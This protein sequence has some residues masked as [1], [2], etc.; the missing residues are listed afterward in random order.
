MSVGAA[1]GAD[2]VEGG[3]GGVVG[4]IE[5]VQVALGGGDR[6]MPE[7]FLDDLEVGAAGQ[8]PGCVGVAE[9]VDADL[10]VQVGLLEG[11][12]PDPV[13]EPVGGDVA[14][15][16]AAAG[17]ARV[18]LAVGAAAGPVFGEGSSAVVA[19]TFGG[20]V[21][22]Q[23]AV[24][25]S[26]SLGVLLGPAEC[27]GVKRGGLLLGCG[28]RL[29]DEQ[30][31]VGTE[32]L[33]DD[34]VFEFGDDLVAE[35]E[36]TPLFIF[37]VVLDQEAF[38][39]GMEL[40]VE[41]HYDAADRQ[42]AGSGFEVAAA[43]FGEF[44]PAQAG[45]DGGLDEEFGVG[46]R[47]GVVEVVE[48]L[49]TDDFQRFLGDGGGADS[50]AG[51]DVGHLVVQRGGEDGAEDDLVVTDGGGGDAVLL[52]APDPGADVLG[53]DVHHPH[54]AE[55]GHDVLVD[56]VVVALHGGR[57]DLVVGQPGLLDVLLEGLPSPLEVEVPPLAYLGL[58]ALPGPVGLLLGGERPR[59][60]DL[61]FEVFV[62]GRVARLAV[63]VQP[64][65]R[66]PQR[67]SPE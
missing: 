5:G 34:V 64:L 57:L 59:R 4:V 12:L 18:V 24:P 52:H 23:R 21:G 54:R 61:A 43:E 1:A 51:V 2:L 42:E 39:L 26:A 55:L 33:F 65:E 63:A 46:V 11:G 56:R 49:G 40:R 48:L 31:P 8:E 62:A 6:S 15:G 28:F 53:E 22:A 25:V 27:L 44:A 3:E 58:G 9:V 14:V 38:P 20:V 32:L 47:E 30:K 36:A 17:F 16:F 37:G 13:A 10:E 19:A 45:F 66:V 7:A 41:F 60:C 35:P 29:V 50:F 67:H